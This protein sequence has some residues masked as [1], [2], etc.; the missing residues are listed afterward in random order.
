MGGA[1][2][3]IKSEIRVKSKSVSPIIKAFNA[4]GWARNPIHRTGALSFSD[5]WVMND[6]TATKLIVA[7]G[8]FST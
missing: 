2:V 8:V 6:C 4:L 3:V 5:S 7:G 1:H